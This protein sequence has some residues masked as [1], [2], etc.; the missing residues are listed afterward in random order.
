MESKPKPIGFLTDVATR[1]TV[2][3]SLSPY[4]SFYS[5]DISVM[6]TTNAV[7]YLTMDRPLCRLCKR[8]VEDFRATYNNAITG[9]YIYTAYC[10]GRTAS[11]SFSREDLINMQRDGDALRDFIM[12]YKFFEADA[13]AVIK[14]ANEYAWPRAAVKSNSGKNSVGPVPVAVATRRKISLLGEE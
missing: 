8:P 9:A 14:E 6:N 5:Y 1:T 10:H 12:G 13:R 7:D 2:S 3:T 11:I 4:D